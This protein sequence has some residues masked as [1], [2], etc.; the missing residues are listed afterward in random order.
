MSARLWSK[1]SRSTA[2]PASMPNPT[3]YRPTIPISAFFRVS[4]AAPPRGSRAPEVVVGEAKAARV[5]DSEIGDIQSF[6]RTGPTG[7]G[8]LPD[9]SGETPSSET[10]V[11][12]KP[13]S[14]PQGGVAP[15][16]A[17]MRHRYHRPAHPQR[18]GG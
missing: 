13:G 11:R 15:P 9:L 14:R 5:P 4:T 16:S 6:V 7:R 3:R 1:R 17:P 10:L 18:P 2:T 8:R 12:T